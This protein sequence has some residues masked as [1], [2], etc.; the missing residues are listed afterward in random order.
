MR[1]LRSLAQKWWN[2]HPLCVSAC[3][4]K[5]RPCVLACLV[6]CVHACDVAEYHFTGLWHHKENLQDV[7]LWL[8]RIG[9]QCWFQGNSGRLGSLSPWCPAFE[10]RKWSNVV[11]VQ[12]GTLADEVRRE[13]EL[14]LALA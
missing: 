14:K 11:C 8:D 6:R 9:Y 4:A 10:F 1:L 13:V 12:K 7:A 3:P 5:L 2:A